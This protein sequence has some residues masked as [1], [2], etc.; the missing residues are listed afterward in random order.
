MDNNLICEFTSNGVRIGPMALGKNLLDTEPNM[1]KRYVI[2]DKVTVLMWK[3]GTKTIIR[4][5]EGDPFNARLGFLTAFFQHHSGLSKNKANKYLA[6]LVVEEPKKEEV[7]EKKII[8]LKVGDKVRVR[9]DLEVGETYGI[10]SFT[11][12]M[13]QL[14]GKEVTIKE[15]FEDGTYFLEEDENWLQFNWTNEMF[16]LERKPKHMKEDAKDGRKNKN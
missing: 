14:L 3:D 8:T 6:S 9:K 16:E 12:Q 2:N 13:K 1:P 4:R 10:D 15:V 7:K 11:P 5:C